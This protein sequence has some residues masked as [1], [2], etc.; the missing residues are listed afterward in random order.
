MALALAAMALTQ[1]AVAVLALVLGKHQSP[2][3]SVV[4]ILMVNALYV[5]LFVAAA[6]LF[7]QAARGRPAGSGTEVAGS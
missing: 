7:R 1:A 4:E 5:A 6:W 2:V 3:S